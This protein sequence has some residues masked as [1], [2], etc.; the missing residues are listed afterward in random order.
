[1]SKLI[2]LF[3][4]FCCGCTH[5]VHD[6]NVEKNTTDL[7]TSN[8]KEHCGEACKVDRCWWE[9]KEVIVCDVKFS[10]RTD[11]YKRDVLNKAS[12]NLG[13]DNR[14]VGFCGR[15]SF[16]TQMLLSA[17]R[18]ATAGAVGAMTSSSSQSSTD[19]VAFANAMGEANEKV[20]PDKNLIHKA[21]ESEPVLDK[22]AKIA[23]K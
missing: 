15:D 23:Q 2:S 3:L 17:V 7:I 14:L 22:K 19:S 12:A 21:C 18:G 1:M 6:L 5:L 11:S 9:N 4:F 8:I 10:F 13:R 20:Y 16:G